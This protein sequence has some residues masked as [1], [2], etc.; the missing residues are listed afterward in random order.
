MK[1]MNNFKQFLFILFAFAFLGANQAWGYSSTKLTVNISGSGKVAVN[2]NTSAP[3]SYSASSVE[4]EQGPHGFWDTKVT[5]TYYIWVSPNTG[6]YC[7]G[8]SDCT[9]NSSGYYFISF[10]GATFTENKTVTATFVG[11]SYSIVFDANGG[12]GSMDKLAMTY[13]TAK[14][15]TNNAFSKTGYSFA[16]W[17]TK[18]NGSGTTYSNKQSVNNLTAAAGGEI[19]LYAQWTP[20]T[21]YVA[22]NCNGCT[23]GE[24]SNQSFTYA[25]AAKALNANQF[26]RAFTTEFNAENGSCET[27]SLVATSTFIGWATTKDGAVVYEDGTTVKD[28]TTTA[29]DIVNLY[30]KWSNGTIVLPNA[31]ANQEGYRLEGWY[32]D[33]ERVG[34]AGTVYTT[35]GNITLQAKWTSQAFDPEFSGADASLNVGE[36]QESAFTF[37]HVDAPIAHIDVTEIDPTNDGSGK[38]IDYDPATNTIIARNAGKATIYFEQEAKPGVNAGESEKWTYTVTKNVPSFSLDKNEIELDQAAMLTLINVD[39]AKVEIVPEGSVIYNAETGELTGKQA[40]KSTITIT[41]EETYFATAKQEVLDLNV[42]KKTPSLSVLLNGLAG[43][44]LTLEYNQ[45]ASFAT[46]QI[47]DGVVELLQIDGQAYVTYA[48]GVF[49]SSFGI[50]TAHFRAV[51]SETDTY[52][53]KSIDFSIN[54]NVASGY[55][56]YTNASGYIMGNPAWTSGFNYGNDSKVLTYQGVPDKLSFSYHYYNDNVTKGDA[57]YMMYVE[58]STDN[59]NWHKIWDNSE[60]VESAQPSGELQLQK[61]TRYIRFN[62]SGNYGAYYTNIK[63]TELRYVDDPEPAVINLG[64]QAINSGEVSGETLI[65]WCNTAPLQVSCDNPRFTVTP[66]SFGDYLRY[67]S[68]ILTVKYTHT[69][70][71]GVNEGDITVTNG[72]YTQKI[73]VSAETTKRPQT[74]LW[75]EQLVATNYTMNVGETYPDATIPYIA[76]T[77]NG[78]LVT[79]LSDNTDVIEIVDDTIIVAKAEGTANITA[80]QVGDAEYQEARNT[81]QFNVTNQLKQSITWEQNLLMLLTTSGEVE[82]TATATSGGAVTYTSDNENIARIEGNKLIVTGEGETFITAIQEGGEID[83]NEYIRATM[84]NTVIVRNPASPCDGRALSVGS[85][86][87]NKNKL[88]QEYTL[89]GTPGNLTFTAKHGTKSGSFIGFSPVY[90]SLIV[91]QYA[92]INNLW[93]WYN[94]FEKVV[95]TDAAGSG[96]IALDESATKIRFRTTETGT[97]HT[98]TSINIPRKKYLRSDVSAIDL[99]VESNAIWSKT[100]TVSHS[101]IDL[102]SVTSTQGLISSNTQIVGKGCDDFGDDQFTVTFTPMQKY[103]HYYDTIVISD[104]KADPSTIVI[105][106]HLYSKGLN[107]GIEGF[108]VPETVKATDVVAPFTATATSLLPVTYSTSDPSIA[109]IVNDNQLEILGVGTIQVIVMQVGDAKYDSTAIERTLVITPA[110]PVI[111]ET[112]VEG[113]IT[114]GDDLTGLELSGSADVE[115]TFEWKNSAEVLPGAGEQTAI[116]IFKPADARYDEVEVEVT[117]NVNLKVLTIFANDT[118][119]EYGSPVPEVFGVR[120]EGF[121][122]GDDPSKLEGALEFFTDYEVGSPKGEYVIVAYGLVSNNYDVY[123]EDGK[124]TVVSTIARLTQTPTA[125][126]DLIYTGQPQELINAGAVDHGQLQY[127][128]GQNGSWSN[129]IPT[130][131]NAGEYTVYYQ[132]P[133]GED[134]TGIEPVAITATI[135]FVGEE[136]KTPQTITWDDELGTMKAGETKVIWAEATSGE[137]V[138]FTSSDPTIA[139][140]EDNMVIV[141]VKGGT[142]TITAH[143]A[144][145]DEYSLAQPVAKELVVKDVA[146]AVDNTDAAAQATKFIRNNQVL[147]IRAGRTYTTTGLLVE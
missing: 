90:S 131:V 45:T 9:W 1:K 79:F 67:S 112:A 104:G 107:Q 59:S 147:I 66:E 144:G 88:S 109:R 89:R 75:N 122:N 46:E 62:F 140:I 50:G 111:R 120:Y 39:G 95:G 126:A 142:V 121:V 28:L 6:Y 115:G 34:E 51:L 47:S 41:Q 23:G 139:Y 53:G 83:G 72:V 38:V 80:I 110:T 71:V 18:A 52:L 60:P 125:K 78:E 84:N 92:F 32:L 42:L 70:E 35:I 29:N 133:D 73:H 134:Y 137:E 123:S 130:A 10:A 102:I 44:S 128:L 54:V 87:L 135:T 143:Q 93:D 56:P 106:V 17:N 40:G 36:R 8:V 76:A 132:V 22:F 97:D 119:I 127:R 20:N 48:N 108:E 26:S 5:D 7:S 113:E 77:A 49:K 21:Y 11:N 33:D 2:T 85:L 141:A 145:N 81:V 14:N 12:S 117:V 68:Q 69:N 27:S 103:V 43:T 86:T 65:N 58:E 118:T 94:V 116:A 37:S 57:D 63:I 105:P 4:A 55:L 61:D 114:Y 24:M 91:E 96:T 98:I 100:I 3:S 146:T 16:G 138:T 124:L 15:L 99:E 64:S 19:I 101:N 129:E 74:I 30:A 13:G 136:G 25:D 82:L 31:T